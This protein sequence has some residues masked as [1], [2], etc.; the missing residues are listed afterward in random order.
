MTKQEIID[1]LEECVDMLSKISGEVDS[2]EFDVQI[3]AAITA[4]SV[5]NCVFQELDEY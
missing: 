4:V 1:T 5:A 2:E 3:D